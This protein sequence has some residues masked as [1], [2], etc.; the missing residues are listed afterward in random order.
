MRYKVS[1][2]CQLSNYNWYTDTQTL[3]GITFTNNK[4]G[5]WTINGTATSG[6]YKSVINLS[7]TSGHKL[8]LCGNLATNPSDVFQYIQPVPTSG[9][10]YYD[11]GSGVIFTA[12]SVTY[13]QIVMCVRS[14]TTVNNAVIKPQ[15]FDL[16]E[17]Y[18]AGNEPTT[19]AQF[20]QDFPDEY[21]EYSPECWK[22]I[23]ELR[24]VAK[25]RNLF[26]IS[27][28]N[29][30]QYGGYWSSNVY[31]NSH[32]YA[33]TVEPGKTYYVSYECYSAN[34][35]SAS[36]ELSL[37]IT[38]AS[39]YYNGTKL[40]VRLVG[41]GNAQGGTLTVP[42][43]VTQ[44]YFTA[45]LTMRFRN[46]QLE[47]GSTA[48]SYQPYG[49]LPMRQGKYIPDK[50][51]IQLVNK[52]TLPST[53]TVGGITFTNNGD[54]S[55]TVNGTTSELVWTKAVTYKGTVGHKYLKTDNSNTS[56][57]Y[58]ETKVSVDDGS[59]VWT[60][61]FFEWKSTYN[62]LYITPVA[63]G[64]ANN[65]VLT[66]QLFDL[67]EIYGAGN[68]P[69]AIAQFREDYPDK[70]YEY[71]T[72]PYKNLFEESFK[73]GDAGAFSATTKRNFEENVWYIGL[74]RNNYNVSH[75]IGSYELK[76]NYAKFTTLV[77][78][79]GVARA[80]K[81]SANKQYTLSF[82]GNAEITNIGFGFYDA[83]GNYLSC[84]DGVRF[85]T[86]PENCAWLTVVFAYYPNNTELYY[87]DIQL[88]EG[89]TATSYQPYK[90][91]S[92][93]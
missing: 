17:M 44:V 86:T 88:E 38:T 67:T 35:N 84:I 36:N 47:E 23:R 42:D 46:L 92:F 33:Q 12:A 68:E 82:K 77:T 64:T 60:E 81:V 72:T 14:G 57:I 83:D 55:I 16:T 1:N 39:G 75:N 74:T 58:I 28:A 3:N 69:T 62:T 9:Q 34:P 87:T 79:Y 53:S 19:V 11:F 70:Y 89:S 29:I 59:T 63:N 93:N 31:I 41:H 5:S 51:V 18:G 20:R 45:F 85:I 24:C 4:D 65:V 8:L 2:V 26:D 73:T 61:P 91:I 13:Y 10:E 32:F 22:R 49:Y 80:F 7:A 40:F 66:P 71:A 90:H 54:G 50:R 27:K 30:T 25:T 76:Y 52:N 78:G 48:T 37:G 43:G 6:C 56:A 21:Y 15:L